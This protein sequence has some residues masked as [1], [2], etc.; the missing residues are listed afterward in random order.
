ME[1]LRPQQTV[2]DKA[3]T[4]RHTYEMSLIGKKI[5]EPVPSEATAR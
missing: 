5:P 1:E 3:I 2:D 4:L